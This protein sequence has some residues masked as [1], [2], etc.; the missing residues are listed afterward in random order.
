[1]YA[2]STAV[3]FQ[4]PV[5]IVPTPV[6]FVCDAVCNVPYIPLDANTSE[7]VIFPLELIAEPMTSFPIICP[8]ASIS[9]LDEI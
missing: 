1:M 7:P 3:P 5:E 9:L 8:C 6:I 4:T 2:V